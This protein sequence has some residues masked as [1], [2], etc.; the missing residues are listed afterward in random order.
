VISLSLS[1]GGVRAPYWAADAPFRPHGGGGRGRA[2][3]PTSRSRV[4]ISSVVTLSVCKRPFDRRGSSSENTRE[5]AG[6]PDA[7]AAHSLL[8]EEG[9]GVS[10]RARGGRALPE[11]SLESVLGGEG[12]GAQ[13]ETPAAL[14]RAEGQGSRLAACARPSVQS[15]GTGPSKRPLQGALLGPHRLLR[16]GGCGAYEGPRTYCPE[17]I[18]ANLR[19][20]P[21][22]SKQL[23]QGRDRIDWHLMRPHSDARSSETPLRAPASEVRSGSRAAGRF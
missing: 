22:L 23:S 4:L 15:C 6:R 16:V 10:A 17:G 5:E 13:T 9:G 3:S 1:W 20:R 11:A 21:G 12:R 7:I 18:N 14:M 8:G 2:N 19:S